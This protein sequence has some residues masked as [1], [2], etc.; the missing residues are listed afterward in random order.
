MDAVELRLGA[1]VADDVAGGPV[2]GH[3]PDLVQIG[4]GHVRILGEKA[5]FRCASA[6]SF[7]RPTTSGAFRVVP[8]VLDLRPAA[9]D[10]DVV[11]DH[12]VAPGVDVA[13]AGGGARGDVAVD[14][15]IALVVIEVDAPAKWGEV[16]RSPDLP[17]P[18]VSVTK[19]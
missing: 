16:Q 7:R 6:Y 2:L 19:L 13:A 15:R 9:L 8:A 11:L 3:V 12:V 14:V 5:E 1:A 4:G 18:S 17:K 10:E